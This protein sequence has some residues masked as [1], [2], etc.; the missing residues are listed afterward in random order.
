MS[1][2][3]DESGSEEDPALESKH[4]S[5]NTLHDCSDEKDTAV[6]CCRAPVAKLSSAARISLAL[7]KSKVPQSDTDIEHRDVSSQRCNIAPTTRIAMAVAA[8]T[9]KLGR[10]LSALMHNNRLRQHS[11]SGRPVFSGC[12]CYYCVFGSFFATDKHKM[13]K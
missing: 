5:T 3:S 10:R 11:S 4:H 13:I 12:I 6:N 9:T 7:S 2:V 1:G 8:Q